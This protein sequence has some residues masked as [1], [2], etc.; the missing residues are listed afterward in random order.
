[1]RERYSKAREDAQLLGVIDTRPEGAVRREAVDPRAQ[2]EQRFPGLDRMA[3]RNDGRGWQVPEPVKRRV[4]EKAAEVLYERRTYFDVDGNE[5]E[6]PP[7]RAAEAQASKTLMT[8]DKFQHEVEHPE[9]RSGVEVNVGVQVNN[10]SAEI[11]ALMRAV[12]AQKQVGRA[13][14]DDSPGRQEVGSGS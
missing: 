7:D 1:V 14:E 3:I 11:A 4:I 13:V 8:A 2:D 6:L 9:A 5:K 10:V 12:E